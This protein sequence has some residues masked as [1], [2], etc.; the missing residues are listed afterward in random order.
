MELRV[1]LLPIYSFTPIIGMNG[2]EQ[3]LMKLVRAEWIF[4]LKDTLSVFENKQ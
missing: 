4:T 3:E 1:V 2:V